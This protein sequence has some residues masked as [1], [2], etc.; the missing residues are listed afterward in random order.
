MEI[1]YIVDDQGPNISDININPSQPTPNDSTEVKA[2]VIDDASGVCNVTLCYQIDE[3][4][5]IELVMS[6]TDSEFNAEISQQKEGTTITFY[7]SASDNADN[8]I[9]SD[10]HA[11]TI[12][13][14]GCFI[15]T[16]TYGSEMAPEVQFL[17]SFRDNMVL[18]T[19][20]GRSFMTLFNEFYYSFSPSVATMISN[21][22]VLRGAAKITL[23]PLIGILHVS[24]ITYTVFGFSP[25]F[26]II[27]AGFVACS[28]IAL[29]YLL[30]PILAVSYFT[31]RRRLNRLTRVLG[32]TW[33]I[34]V[35]SMILGEIT[36][37]QPLMM[38]STGAFVIATI[39]VIITF[40]SNKLYK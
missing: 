24:S 7:I 6:S 11:F 21:N 16:S 25:E 2:T 30:P 18:N 26:G 34:S 39:C 31:K 40:V 9:A 35:L 13:K 23:Y 22:E 37:Y 29:I 27:I 8:I 32:I 5:W 12:K 20:A 28:L 10:K 36:L 3:G 19:F 14:S 4:S 33:V 1:T 17:R 38:L 15:A